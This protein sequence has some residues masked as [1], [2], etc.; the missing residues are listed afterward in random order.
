MKIF[1]GHKLGNVALLSLG[2]ILVSVG[3]GV[4]DC[5]SCGGTGCATAQTTCNATAQ[6]T[7]DDTDSASLKNEQ[8][9][10]IYQSPSI[11]TTTYN[12]EIQLH[13][14]QYNK[15][16]AACQATYNQCS[17]KC[18]TITATA[19]PNGSVSGPN[20]YIAPPGVQSGLEPGSN[21]NVLMTPNYC[22]HVSSVLVDNTAVGIPIYNTTPATS[23]S[24]SFTNLT[25]DHTLASYY[26]QNS[27][28]I[29]SSAGSGGSITP[30]ESGI[31]CG[32]SRTYTLTANTGF[33]IASLLVDGSAASMPN[34]PV[35]GQ[36][37]Y[38]YT[39]SNIIKDYTIS[40]TFSDKYPVYATLAG[41]GKGAVTT[42][43]SSFTCTTGTCS[44]Q[45]QQGSSVTLTAA[46]DSDS[47]FDGW[48]GA[49][50]GTVQACTVTMT[51]DKSATSTFKILPPVAQF[52]VSFGGSGTPVPV[53]FINQSLRGWDSSRATAIY[54]A[55]NGGTDGYA[56]TWDFGDGT[57]SHDKNPTHIYKVAATYTVALTVKNPTGSNTTSTVITVTP[58]GNLPVRVIPVVGSPRYFASLAE[59]YSS[60][61]DGENIQA[62]SINFRENINSSKNV[63]FT[64]G[65]NCDFGS[66]IDDTTLQGE[67]DISDSQATMANL[68]LLTDQSTVSYVDIAAF[69]TV[70]GTI[71][72][73]GTVG[74]KVG[75]NFTYVIT[76]DPGV[77]ILDVQVDGV[78]VGAV[79]QYNFA[80]VTQNHAIKA[81]FA[82]KLTISSAGEGGGT[83]TST[84]AAIACGSSCSAQLMAGSS[85]VLTATPDIYSKFLGWSGG[86]C[87][88]T[89]PCTVVMNSDTN[90]TASFS[91]S[92]A[93]IAGT[94]PVTFDSIQAA[95]DAAPD[96]A[97]IQVRN[98]TMV[99][100]LIANAAKTIT[101]NGGYD[102]TYSTVSG[103]STLK[104]TLNT[105]S[106]ATTINTINVHQ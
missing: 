74:V 4:S 12:Q 29:A 101:I 20:G 33:H 86:G 14:D 25:T 26:G 9:C 32:N 52:S 7:K 94:T 59:A 41:T 87:S 42:N 21:F 63:N 92:H 46:P 103:I 70:G 50:S 27:Y 104:G 95:Y 19:G 84:P 79:S 39:F 77:A 89:A 34:S 10:A 80:N 5:Y 55:Y 73:A 40:G 96:G 18:I 8:N 90:V 16:I 91:T 61:S 31:P 99:E 23:I 11:C 62:L 78:S 49:C 53:T 106:G 93:Q 100:S 66:V 17:A 35:Y 83:V 56:Y 69:S 75:G 2:A 54:P 22:Y 81:I 102:K 97:T 88:G 13:L 68:S 72:P 57:S 48:S 30:P 47:T 3:T 44:A 45:F 71:T 76:P 15:D 67:V 24:Y 58:C 36:A 38:S 82:R 43:P 85:V 98:L 64:G 60:A 65:F 105:T 1:H 28:T 37:T 6:Q 51:Y